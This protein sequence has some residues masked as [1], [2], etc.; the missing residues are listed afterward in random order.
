VKATRAISGEKVL[1]FSFASCRA[2]SMI[3]VLCPEKMG[4]HGDLQARA[5]AEA[6]RTGKDVAE[7]GEQVSIP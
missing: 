3:R 2:V 7:I 1:I 6:L 5:E 4:G